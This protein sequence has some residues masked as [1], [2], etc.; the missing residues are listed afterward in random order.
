[1]RLSL[2][3]DFPRL[4]RATMGWPSEPKSPRGS[5]RLWESNTTSTVQSSGEVEQP[6][7]LLKRH[8]FKLVQE[9]HL[10][11]PRL[12]LLVL[13]RLR[14]TPN[15]LGLPLFEALYGRPFFEMIS[16]W[17]LGLPIWCSTPPSQPNS[18]RFFLS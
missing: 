7:G 4:S 18:N 17:T 16:F 5:L 14:N 11:W 13:T 9:N 15:S 6:N 2:D 12:L 3:L 1:M 8:L 10:P